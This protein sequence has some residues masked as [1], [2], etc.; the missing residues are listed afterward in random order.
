MTIKDPMNSGFILP[1]D[2][3]IGITCRYGNS[4]EVDLKRGE[5][6][7]KVPNNPNN[8]IL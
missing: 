8:S 5:A 1:P 2:L 3:R 6:A 4:L 7:V